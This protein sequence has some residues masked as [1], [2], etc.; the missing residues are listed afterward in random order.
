MRLQ[1]LDADHQCEQAELDPEVA[2]VEASGAGGA[3]AS[4]RAPYADRAQR[5]RR[6]GEALEHGP[7]RSSGT[8]GARVV[9][10]ASVAAGG[11]L[12][13]LLPP[14]PPQPATAAIKSAN[15]LME[16]L[17]PSGILLTEP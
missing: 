14:R 2:P 6:D 16:A 11:A 3:A 5:H 17:V 1:R 15:T 13:S 4:S 12:T 7:E 10:G 8:G 9:V